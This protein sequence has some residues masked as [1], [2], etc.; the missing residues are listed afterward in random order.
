MRDVT[1]LSV[2]VVGRPGVRSGESE[3]ETAV[4]QTFVWGSSRRLAVSALLSEDYLG[5]ISGR[6]DFLMEGCTKFLFLC[7]VSETRVYLQ[8]PAPG[9][10]RG[11]D[12]LSLTAPVQVPVFP[13]CRVLRRVLRCPL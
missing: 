5:D 13:S 2:R 7:W 8:T 11:L 9:T 6:P 4:S 12:S 10:R 1:G 3:L